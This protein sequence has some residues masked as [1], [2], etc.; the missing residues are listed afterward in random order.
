[1]HQFNFKIK[2]KLINFKLIKILI[3]KLKFFK[4]F[5]L[6]KM[7]ILKLKFFKNFKIN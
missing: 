2:L 3:L 7:L 5:K 6:I 1:M 4:N